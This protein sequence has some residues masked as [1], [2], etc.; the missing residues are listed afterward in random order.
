MPSRDDF[1]LVRQQEP[2]VQFRVAD[3]P[4]MTPGRQSR[5]TG[6]DYRVVWRRIGAGKNT[7][8]RRSAGR[9]TARLRHNRRELTPHR[10][11]SQ[12]YL[13]RIRRRSA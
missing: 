9:C 1:Y 3:A 4:G 8:H 6:L 2:V 10:T 13:P 11:G 7:S 5:G 12:R